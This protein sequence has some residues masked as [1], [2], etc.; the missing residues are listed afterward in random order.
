[1]NT[2]GFSEPN[3]QQSSNNDIFGEVLGYRDSRPSASEFQLFPEK[4]AESGEGFPDVLLGHFKQSDDDNKNS[5]Q[6]GKK[7]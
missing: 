5:V 2:S 1:V 7:S 4:L 6:T 3:P